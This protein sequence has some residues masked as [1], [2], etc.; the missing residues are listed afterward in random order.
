MAT[1]DPRDL[2][3][4]TPQ[5]A[6]HSLVLPVS[7]LRAW[8]LGAHT[9]HPVIKP[10]RRSP[11]TLSFFN[12]AELYVLAAMRRH[13]RVSMPKVRKALA[14]VE[15]EIG[16]QRPLLAQEFHTDGVDLFVDKYSALIAVSQNGQHM[17]RQILIGSLKR[18]DRDRKILLPKRLFPWLNAPDEP[19]TVEINHD[20][21]FGR[22]TLIGT[23]IPTLSL[24]ERFRAGESVDALVEDYRLTRSQV[25]AALRWEERALAA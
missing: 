5:E 14:Y 10:A 16:V 12:V 25:E 8:S 13:H 23:G 22:L 17:L 9:M 6:A 3:Q 15:R 4:Y 11:L 2:P 21:A 19:R 20:R 7:T 18:I 24:A 1:T